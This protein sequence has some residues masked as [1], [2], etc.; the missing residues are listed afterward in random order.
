MRAM[1]NALT[2]AIQEN[3]STASIVAAAALVTEAVY[4]SFVIFI[5]RRNLVIRMAKPKGERAYPSVLLRPWHVD[6]SDVVVRLH[7]QLKH[8]GHYSWINSEHGS[9]ASTL[10]RMMASRERLV[11]YISLAAAVTLEE[12]IEVIREELGIVE[13]ERMSLSLRLFHR[14]LK[15][16]SGGASEEE[17]STEASL[18]WIRLTGLINSAA[19]LARRSENTRDPLVFV[20]DHVGALEP[21]VI[22]LLQ[23]WASS[24]KSLHIVLVASNFRLFDSEH[25]SSMVL[26]WLLRFL[27][28][29]P[30]DSC[31]A[32]WK[33]FQGCN[34]CPRRLFGIAALRSCDG[35]RAAT[36]VSSTGPR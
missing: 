24:S 1:F 10:L 23:K 29:M 28:R 33:P 32:V 17:D 26:R 9:G 19:E 22:N 3:F 6:R 16:V 8:T 2:D 5:R 36:L 25:S 30:H 31:S 27:L 35:T 18:A 21:D 12:T 13:S 14:V 15:A 34:K 20:L 7:T 11:Q 4:S